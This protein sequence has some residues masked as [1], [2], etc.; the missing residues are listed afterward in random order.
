MRKKLLSSLLVTAMLS[1]DSVGDV[2]ILLP[3]AD[4]GVSLLRERPEA[5]PLDSTRDFVP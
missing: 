4:T 3:P 5:L 2:F 1:R